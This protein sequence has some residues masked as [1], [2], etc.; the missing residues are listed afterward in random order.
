MAETLT[1]IQRRKANV[2]DAGL[3]R[4]QALQLH[5]AAHSDNAVG[6]KDA[7]TALRNTAT[8]I[9]MRLG[10]WENGR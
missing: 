7:S 9:L 1:P 8:R 10:A 3:A 4:E 5:R 2:K 6:I